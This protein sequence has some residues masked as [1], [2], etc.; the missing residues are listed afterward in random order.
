MARSINSQSMNRGSLKLPIQTNHLQFKP[1]CSLKSHMDAVR[2][3][4]FVPSVGAL[5]SASE[6]CTLK[7]WHT[8]TLLESS[9]VD[10][11][12]YITMRGHT[13]PVMCMTGMPAERPYDYYSDLVFS[14]GSNGSI[15]IWRVPPSSH[16]DTYGEDKE[17]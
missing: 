15:L 9:S 16:I 7:A 8:Q 14:G 17:D 2:G 4:H 6:D 13:G 10:F 3:L 12:P 5:V 11:E 1:K